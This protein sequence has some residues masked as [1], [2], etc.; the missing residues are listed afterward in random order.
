MISVE[1]GRAGHNSAGEICGLAKTQET[2]KGS[3]ESVPECVVPS[4]KF[5]T[6]L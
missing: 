6:G 3:L 1:L 2:R 5:T 4:L